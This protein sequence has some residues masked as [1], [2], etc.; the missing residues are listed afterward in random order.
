MKLA[1]SGTLDHLG[2]GRDG[3]TGAEER[4]LALDFA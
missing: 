1:G 2:S 4:W 3:S